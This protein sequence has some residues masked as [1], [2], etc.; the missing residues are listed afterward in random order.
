MERSD[1]D[2]FIKMYEV[3]INYFNFVYVVC[4]SRDKESDVS[5]ADQLLAISETIPKLGETEICSRIL[6]CLW[7]KK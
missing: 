4:F 1:I 3:A 7:V 6:M 5:V 2:C